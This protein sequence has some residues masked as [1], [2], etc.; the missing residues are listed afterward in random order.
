M[1]KKWA[2]LCLLL[3][4]DH[5]KSPEMACQ[6]FRD[7][8][9]RRDGHGCVFYFLRVVTSRETE[10]VPLPRSEHMTRRILRM[11]PSIFRVPARFHPRRIYATHPVLKSSHSDV[12]YHRRTAVHCEDDYTYLQ[13]LERIMVPFPGIRN[14]IFLFSVD[15][16]GSARER[17]TSPGPAPRRGVLA[18]A[19]E[20]EGGGDKRRRLLFKTDATCVSGPK[21]PQIYVR[22]A[23]IILSLGRGNANV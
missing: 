21:G 1:S 15:Q 17:P 2:W 4:Y 16:V 5:L 18:G 13:I 9:C 12:T 6:T 3:V 11:R 20:R 14:G 10:S 8:W 19:S 23:G 7:D 22:S